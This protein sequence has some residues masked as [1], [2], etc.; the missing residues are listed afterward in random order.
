MTVDSR[1]L[2]YGINEF[3]WVFINHQIMS[4]V[5]NFIVEILLIL[6]YD[7]RAVHQNIHDSP[8]YVMWVV[9]LEV[10]I[11]TSISMYV[12]SRGGPQPAPAPRPSL[13]YC[14][15]QYQ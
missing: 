4:Y 7:L 9:E 12:Y 8:F 2:H 1:W 11:T 10:Q 14:A 6:T 3:L 15:S 13:I 5:L